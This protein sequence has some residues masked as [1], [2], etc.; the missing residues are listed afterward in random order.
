M[1]TLRLTFFSIII[2][3]FV[4]TLAIFGFAHS[5]N[6]AGAEG[7]LVV[8]AEGKM[9]GSQLIAQGFHSSRYF[10]PR[11]SACDY[12]AQ[13]SGGTNLSPRDPRVMSRAQEIIAQ[14]KSGNDAL[15]PAD[16]VSCSGSGL[17]PH[18]SEAAALY[19]AERIAKARGVAKQRIVEMI[20]AHKHALMGKWGGTNLL[21]VLELNIA[22]DTLSP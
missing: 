2:C 11:P 17:D 10:H 4:Y 13:A 1:T 14:E 6:P 7:S 12:N 20:D 18:I 9:I 8:N 16:L 22:I 3:G 19:Q 15:I 21:N 5:V